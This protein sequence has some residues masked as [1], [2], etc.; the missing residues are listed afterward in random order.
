MLVYTIRRFIRINAENRDSNAALALRLSMYIQLFFITYC[1]SGNPLY[2]Y[3]FVVTY[4]IGIA[5][6]GVNE[7]EYV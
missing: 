6:L 7:R 4:F 2:D 1:F 5:L 3:V